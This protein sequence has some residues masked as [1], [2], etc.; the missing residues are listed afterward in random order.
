MLFLPVSFRC[1]FS[2]KLLR[3]YIN[4]GAKRLPIH[5]IKLHISVQRLQLEL[6][7]TIYAAR[8]HTNGL[9]AVIQA[10][11]R[12]RLRVPKKLS[13]NIEHTKAKD[14]P[15]QAREPAGLIQVKHL[16]M[17]LLNLLWQ[18]IKYVFT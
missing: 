16:L 14:T 18:M 9:I 3:H 4:A 7:E 10:K 13:L 5:V 6:Y 12:S 2:G 1:R 15:V 11:L 8:M 17:R